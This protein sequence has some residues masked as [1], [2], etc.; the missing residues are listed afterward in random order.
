M[1]VVKFGTFEFSTA[2]R[3]LRRDGRVVSIE[4]QPARALSVLL[5]HAGDVVSREDLIKGVWGNDVHVDFDRG[6]AYVIGH[7]RAALGDSADNP[8]FVQTLPRKGFRFI[9]PVDWTDSMR[10]PGTGSARTAPAPAK[11]AS[12]PLSPVMQRFQRLAIV[13]VVMAISSAAA[14]WFTRMSAKPRPLIAVSIFDNETGDARFDRFVGGLS[15]LVVSRLAADGGSRLGVVGNAPALRTARDQRD[16]EA[17][18]Q[19]TNAGFIVLGQ[20]QHDPAG[21]RIIVHLL[22]LDDKSHMWAQRIVRPANA[23]EGA[24]QSVADEVTS[25][26]TRFVLNGETPVKN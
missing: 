25:A 17:I 8:R 4:P 21:L 24:S 5:E 15:D 3:E 1:S 22:R 10:D 7:V 20:L 18:R 14:F 19:A 9:A 26:V 13:V 2:S 12:G 6:L 16:L 11:P 23:I